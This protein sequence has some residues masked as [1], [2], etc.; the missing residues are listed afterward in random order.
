M[1][2]MWVCI[3][4]IFA[5]FGGWIGMFLGG[6]DGPLLAL[7]ALITIDYI[8]GVMCGIVEHRLSSEIG[9]KGIFRKITM[10]MLVG[11]G[12]ML[13]AYVVRTGDVVRTAIIF[14]YI[15]NEGVSLI[16]NAARLGLP[17]PPK[18]R[19]I[20]ESIKEEGKKS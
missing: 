17:V 11:V 13:D 14:Y 7:V 20:L 3:K 15:S 12:A 19:N 8:T 2:E 9:F 16:E 4:V 10:L 18:V 1:K 5:V 6:W